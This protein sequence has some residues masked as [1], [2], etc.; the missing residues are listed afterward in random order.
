MD[1]LNPETRRKNMKAIR[2][3]HTKLEDKVCNEL[4]KRGY[5]FRRNVRSLYGNPD[6]A[7]KKYKIVIFI[8][9]CFW[10]GCSVH[11]NTPKSNQEY[12]IMKLNRNV[13]RDRMVTDY[14]IKKGWAILRIWEH[15]LKKDL[16][17][18][19]I[20]EVCSFIDQKK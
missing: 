12:W 18:Q 8:D 14:Y 2:S 6:I 4:W 19:T 7:I 17:F 15:Q 16:F 13:E 3:T 11:G 1:N 9:S 5:R 10:H 20:E